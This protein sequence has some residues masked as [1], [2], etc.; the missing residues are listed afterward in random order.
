MAE[1]LGLWG[2]GGE[3]N[4]EQNQVSQG[5]G[6]TNIAT[7]EPFPMS[8]YWQN[9]SPLLRAMAPA[10]LTGASHSETA[11]DIEIGKNIPQ[12]A[13]EGE[14]HD[15][16]NFTIGNSTLPLAASPIQDQDD[17]DRHFIRHNH[18][19]HHYYHHH[20]SPPMAGAVNA[21]TDR[22]VEP[23]SIASFVDAIT[24]TQ[25][26]RVHIRVM[27]DV[28]NMPIPGGVSPLD[29]IERLR[30]WIFHTLVLLLRP[31]DSTI[32]RDPQAQ[33]MKK[34]EEDTIEEPSPAPLRSSP[35]L[36]RTRSSTSSVPSGP[37]ACLWSAGCRSSPSSSS[38][39]A[40][41]SWATRPS[42]SAR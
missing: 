41:S 35:L 39:P 12:K 33:R 27:W 31:E 29:C 5:V 28:E 30:A 26:K 14:I 6:C 4:N 11:N 32:K 13:D 10:S 34:D 23:N 24:P 20:T 18:H 25:Q 40:P 9:E 7:D 37:P 38:D 3:C 19:Y 16:V 17:Q 22:D 21:A 2:L 8:E 36:S 15:S 1:S 42:S